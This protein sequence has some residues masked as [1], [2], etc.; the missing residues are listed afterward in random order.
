VRITT[1][2]GDIALH[3]SDVEPLP[4]VSPAAPKIT[5]APAKPAKHAK[6]P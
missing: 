1:E 2:N 4:A 5:L 6:T 3:K